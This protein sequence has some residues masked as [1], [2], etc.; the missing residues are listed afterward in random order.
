MARILDR[1]GFSNFFLKKLIIFA[2]KTR[3]ELATRQFDYFKE[4]NQ[5]L[6]EE[7]YRDAAICYEISFIGPAAGGR[8]SVPAGMGRRGV[9]PYAVFIKQTKCIHATFDGRRP[10]LHLSFDF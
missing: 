1:H 6:G 3:Q 5:K 7:Y 9:R 2:R 4:D 10:M 8:A